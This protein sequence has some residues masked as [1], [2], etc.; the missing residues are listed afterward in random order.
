MK[1]YWKIISICLV[2]LMVI[3]TFYIQSSFAT[4]EQLDIVFEK[5]NGNED[6]VKNVML[7]GD[8]L[9]DQTHFYRQYTPLQMTSEETIN[10]NNLSFLQKLSGMGVPYYLEDLV[11]KHRNF[12]RSK[13]LTP[14]Y[15]FEDENVVAY[16][17]INA[18]NNVHPMKELTFDIELLT[19]KSEE[20]TSIQLDV[21]EGENY[22][23]MQV[24]DV[25]VIEG[26]LKVITSGFRIN[27]GDELRVYTFDMNVQKV[28]SEHTIA[29]IPPVENG[30]SDLRIVDEGT[31]IQSNNYLLIR[32]K[33]FEDEMGHSDGE[34]SEVA[35]EFIIYDLKNNQSKK[36]VG[37]A[38]ILDSIGSDSAIFNSTILIPT[39]AE[40]S[41]EVSHY[42]IANEKWDK[43]LA[44]DLFGTKDDENAPYMKVMNGKIYIIY[45]TT[46]GHNIVIGDL[47]TGKSL[48]EGKIKVIN[49]EEDQKDYRVYFHDIEYIQ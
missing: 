38:D 31:S 18:K 34:M 36:I 21:P 25:Q 7:Y 48:Y 2:T 13:D 9:I 14:N 11:E 15:F 8:Y 23:W 46:N 19:K 5:V 40:N 41:V 49:L 43:K 22:S 6:E 4:N 47:K 16:A 44:F 45:S 1:R 30:W 42:D 26:E 17:K 27:S 39:Q 3:G 37:P 20:V 35:N 10:L 24:E 33:A 12:M 29:S 32:I 28:V